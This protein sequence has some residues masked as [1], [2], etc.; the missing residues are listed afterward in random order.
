M[1][2]LVASIALTWLAIILPL[3]ARAQAVTYDFS[4]TVTVTSGI[5]SSIALGSPITGTYTFDLANADPTQSTGTVGSA[6]ESWDAELFGGSFYAGSPPPVNSV[7]FSSKA[8]VDGFTYSSLAPTPYQTLSRVLAEPGISTAYQATE[9]ICLNSAFCSTSSLLGSAFLGIN[10]TSEGL[11]DF[12]LSPDGWTGELGTGVQ[13]DSPDFLRFSITSLAPETVP[14]PE[15]SSGTLAGLGA[16][17]LWLARRRN[18]RS[19]RG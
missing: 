2:R 15:P 11:P 16:L 13:F 4:G 17:A 14:V 12:S 5:Y 3:V 8:I 10:Y 6:T 7:V 19:H 1:R 18:L 9:V